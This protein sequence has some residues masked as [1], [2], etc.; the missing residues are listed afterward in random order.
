[1]FRTPDRLDLI[2]LGP[3]VFSVNRLA[4][5]LGWSRFRDGMMRSSACFRRLVPDSPLVRISL[6]YL[7]RFDDPA[8]VGAP[9]TNFVSVVRSGGLEG[10]PMGDF[11]VRSEYRVS[12]DYEAVG[13]QVFG[14]GGAVFLAL[15]D[16]VGG[17]KAVEV[18]N[19][20]ESL[21]DWFES[22]HTRLCGAFQGCL[23]ES[24]LRSLS[25]E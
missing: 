2:Q 15:T 5:Y 7:N 12:E 9:H 4:P 8:I 17:M 18:A 21:S 13:V 20:E 14:Q 1:M 3:G 24:L 19:A 10:L 6:T 22:A 23:H 16:A 25:G 11:F